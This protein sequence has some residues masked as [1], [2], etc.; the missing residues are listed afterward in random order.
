MA[1]ERR[2]DSSTTVFIDEIDVDRFD[3]PV[4]CGTFWIDSELRA[5]LRPAPCISLQYASRE[6][7][8]QHASALLKLA[9]KWAEQENAAESAAPREVA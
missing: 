7:I 1:R 5:V 2:L 8:L 6:A 3:S 9:K 4:N